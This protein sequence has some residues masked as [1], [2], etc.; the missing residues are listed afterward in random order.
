MVIFSIDGGTSPQGQMEM[1]E[2]FLDV[3][4]TGVLLAFSAQL[5]SM[6]N[7]MH[8]EH[9]WFILKNCPAQNAN[10]ISVEKFLKNSLLLTYWAQFSPNSVNFKANKRLIVHTRTLTYAYIPGFKPLLLVEETSTTECVRARL[11]VVCVYMIS[12]T[13]AANNE[14][15]GSC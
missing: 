1:C 4:M 2:R 12:V 9:R 8:L 10:S 6:L 5:P 14:E 15:R 7:I 13:M 3:T 11:E